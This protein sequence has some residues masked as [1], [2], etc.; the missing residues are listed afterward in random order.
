MKRK[1]KPDEK[2]GKYKAKLL[3]LREQL[4][5]SVSYLEDNAQRSSELSA[6]R[7]SSGSFSSGDHLADLGA[8][9]FEKDRLLRLRECGE[10]AIDEIDAALQR[11][12][13]GN[14]GICQGCGKKIP[15][16]R[17]KALP[18]ARLCVKCQQDQE[19]ADAQYP[20]GR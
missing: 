2:N 7:S 12:N 11:I 9:T 8:D 5:A 6:T 15:Q 3:E 1:A 18:Y 19:R 20:Y 13:E 4:T 10:R 16:T 17:L 14:Y